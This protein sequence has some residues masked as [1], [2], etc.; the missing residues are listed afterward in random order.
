MFAPFAR[1]AAVLGLL[2]VAAAC[3]AVP[4]EPPVALTP[5]VGDTSLVVNSL[6]PAADAPAI[7]NPVVTFYAKYDEATSA[8]MYYRSRPGRADSVDFILFRVPREALLTRP[9][10]S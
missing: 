3:T 7:A 8:Y 2:L 4:N 6:A 1:R 5:T 9:D 10:G